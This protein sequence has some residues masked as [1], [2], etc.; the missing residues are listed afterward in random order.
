MNWKLILFTTKGN[1]THQHEKKSYEKT[2]KVKHRR[3]MNVFMILVSVNC[4]SIPMHSRLFDVLTFEP[5]Y[6]TV[7]FNNSQHNVKNTMSGNLL[8]IATYEKENRMYVIQPFSYD[9][10]IAF[11]MYISI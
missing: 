2:I 6:S 1:G 8:T 4:M 3:M 11:S 10:L 9:Q 7:K 5:F